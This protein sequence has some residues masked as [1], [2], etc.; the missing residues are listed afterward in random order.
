V[1]IVDVDDCSALRGGM[2]KAEDYSAKERTLSQWQWSRQEPTTV[3]WAVWP[4]QAQRSSANDDEN[5]NS[6][7]VRPT[8]T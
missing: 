3:M 6:R 4:C 2:M 1:G 5:C 8:A 7:I